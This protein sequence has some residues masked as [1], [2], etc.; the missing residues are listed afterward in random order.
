M[1][2]DIATEPYDEQYHALIDYAVAHSDA[3]MLVFS[4][5]KGSKFQGN[6]MRA[7]RNHLKEWRMKTRHDAQWP[8]T[9]SHDTRWN[10]TI[11]LYAPSLEVKEY[12][13]SQK[14][15]YAW[16]RNGVPGDISFFRNNHCW[17]ASCSLEEFGWISLDEEPQLS[18][19]Q[20][21][22]KIDNP[23]DVSY[24]EDY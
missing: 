19:M 4:T 13:L 15:L 7:I 3:V 1:I 17:L 12:L 24:F 10:F 5:K 23:N 16:G 2:Y 18:F 22:K 11:D 20:C 21:L 9:T 14:S 8:V 6:T